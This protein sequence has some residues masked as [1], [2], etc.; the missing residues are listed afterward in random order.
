MRYAWLGFSETRD[1]PRGGDG[2][3]GALDRRNLV[4]VGASAGGVE[5]LR[6]LVNGL[7]TD[8]PATVL[9][10]LHVPESAHSALPAILARSG[11]VVVKEAAEGDEL[12]PGHVL[13]APPGRH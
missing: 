5:P 2:E 6:T 9:V 13:T 10:V 12:L 1:A 4:V 7:P 8:F 11:R 3:G